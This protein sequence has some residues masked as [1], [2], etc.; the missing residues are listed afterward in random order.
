MKYLITGGTG[1]VGSHLS[2][3]LLASG[4][5]VTSVDISL[6]GDVVQALKNTTD[7]RKLKVVKGDVIK[8]GLLNRL[9]EARHPDAI[10]HLA[11][12]M[13]ED[14]GRDSTQSIEVNCL[15]LARVLESAVHYGVSRVVWASSIAAGE[16]RE[17]D[18][19][20]D[21][22]HW[23]L[24]YAA[25]MTFNERLAKVYHDKF[26]LEVFSLRFPYIYGAGRVRGASFGQKMIV[27]S[28][29]GKPVRVPFGDEVVDWLYI[30]DAVRAIGCALACKSSH[31]TAYSVGG[32]LR[33]VRE[34]A[35]YLRGLC[36]GARIELEPGRTGLTWKSDFHATEADLGYRPHFS[37][38]DGIRDLQR[39]TDSLVN[40]MP[41]DPPSIRPPGRRAGAK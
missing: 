25:T 13:G 26:N 10:I 28:L 8:K 32:D 4:H 19:L 9:I 5:E 20:D 17:A 41:P 12:L 14:C 21:L 6:D 40:R 16:H 27:R 36:P 38:E 29:A 15:G 24:I 3:S 33:S 35:D 1:F 7:R 23:A 37:L 39:Q 30:D 18:D 34:V 31:R 11:A 2:R 22:P